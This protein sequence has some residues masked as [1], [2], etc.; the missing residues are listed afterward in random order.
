MAKQRKTAYEL[1]ESQVS[2]PTKVVSLFWH[3]AKKRRE[4]LGRVLDLG[5]GDARFARKG[6][7]QHYVGVE[8]DLKKSQAAVLPE[9]ATLIHNCAFKHRAKSYDACIGNPP[10]VRHHDIESPWKENIVARLEDELG[11][12]INKHCN[13]YLYFFCL[14]LIKTTANGLVAFVIPYEWVSRPSAAS[15]REYI[16]KQG[17]D[18][19]VYRFQQPI[20][21]D[22]LTTASV[23]IVDKN[24]RRGLWKY[25]DVTPNF[26]VKKRNGVA[27]SKGG[28]LKYSDRG[29]VWALRGLSPGSQKVFTLTDGERL[30]F[31]LK[32]G[33]VVPCV[34]TLKDVPSSL[35][36][37][38]KVS[39]KT[40]FVDAGKR[41]WLI[42][43]SSRTK[44]TRLKSYLRAVP[45]AIRDTYT[46]RNQTPW[47]NYRPHPIPQ[48]L[49]GSGFT[50]FGPKVLVNSVAA[51]A[52]GSVWGIHSQKPL[53]YRRL[54]RHLLNFDFEKRVVAHA[55]TL[56]KIE[57]KQLN[58][59]L[60]K[61]T[62]RDRSHVHK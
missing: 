36:M 42:K 13:L 57:V 58:T 1:S 6:N 40:Y 59:V 28:V 10:Y 12:A 46:C 14:G 5:A 25:Y 51:H 27:D 52:V 49:L 9:N 20:F 18:V 2:T 56:K 50:K 45:E 38:T 39:F 16:R 32:K 53:P 30:R 11:I 17:W 37:L 3:L 60:N 34:T 23:S 24:S 21:D 44:S 31:G 62:K 26:A 29:D 43:S 48:I 54:Q 22:V 4:K 55:R 41:C 8:I 19:M 61:F 47:Y 7:F 15:L 35:K 33:D